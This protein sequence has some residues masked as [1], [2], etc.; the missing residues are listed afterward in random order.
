MLLRRIYTYPLLY[1]IL[2]L[3]A[4]C[5]VPAPAPPPEQIAGPRNFKL[6]LQPLPQE[7]E[8]L[9]IEL[10]SARALRSDGRDIPLQLRH[11]DLT[12]QPRQA[13]D[14]R[15]LIDTQLPPGEY[16]AITLE[17]AAVSLR[18]PDGP[19]ALLPPDEPLQLEH[20]F[21][22]LSDSST[23]LWLQL[24]GDPL[25]TD[26]AFF[27][28]RLALWQPSRLLPRL[29]GFVSNSTSGDLTVFNKRTSEVVNTLQI[30]R[31]PMDLALDQRKGT[32]YV[33]L[34]GDNAVAVI[35]VDSE[36]PV[37][38]VA[39]RF[40]D[41][42]VELALS[43]DGSLL[44]ALNRG[45]S[46]LSL[47]DTG[48]L[49]ETARVRLPEEGEGLFLGTG[50]RFAYV[51]HNVTDSLSV[52][53]LQ[54]AQLRQ[55]IDLKEAPSDGVADPDGG[56][57]YLTSRQSGNLTALDEHAADGERQIFIGAQA[58]TI[59]PERNSGLLYIGLDNG[60]V[61]VVDPRADMAIDFFPLH[62]GAVRDLAIDRDQN[63]LF[64][65]VPD[66]SRLY[67]VDLISKRLLGRTILNSGATSVAVM[68]ER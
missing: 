17:V 53:H 64:V 2:L 1:L 34:A 27:T 33:A 20:A 41:R 59:I 8:A 45:S 50:E 43:R 65:L 22:I 61:A 62:Y 66:R 23:T 4:G 31:Q 68:G 51:A 54:T 49:F 12:Y 30:G 38:R 46:T 24:A 57:L 52:I 19:V 37:G 44:L 47:I 60:A 39:L 67:K 35:D 26:G 58:R 9:R 3:I 21:R 5:T 56:A 48:S 42:P 40:G 63:S 25:V 55:T 6:F 28:P 10:S 36:E 15:L 16:R 29:K 14:Q 11:H 32:L 7:A 18:T 13:R